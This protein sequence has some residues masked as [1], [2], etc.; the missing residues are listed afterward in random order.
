[1]P[2]FESESPG[3]HGGD[4]GVRRDGQGPSWP[5]TNDRGSL[6]QQALFRMK[7]GGTVARSIWEFVLTDSHRIRRMKSDLRQD[8]GEVMLLNGCRH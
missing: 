6:V 3:G 1:M 8:R 7:R 2:S 5:D 4:L